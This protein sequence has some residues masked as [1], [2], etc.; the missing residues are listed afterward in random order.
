MATY[1]QYIPVAYPSLP[2]SALGYNTSTPDI[3]SITGQQPASQSLQMTSAAQQAPYQSTSGTGSSAGP[4]GTGSSAGS[5]STGSSNPYANDPYYNPT[6]GTGLANNVGSQGVGG[7][8]SSAPQV[9]QSGATVPNPLGNNST[10]DPSLKNPNAR[11]GIGNTGS[12]SGATPTPAIA[13][14]P[15]GKGTAQT[16]TATDG[17]TTTPSSSPSSSAPYS[18]PTQANYTPAVTAGIGNQTDAGATIDPTTRQYTGGVTLGMQGSPLFANTPAGQNNPQAQQAMANAQAGVGGQYTAANVPAEPTQAGIDYSNPQQ[19]AT[20]NSALGATA[21]GAAADYQ[22]NP[23]FNEAGQLMPAGTF[24][25]QNGKVCVV[26]APY[27]PD[28][29]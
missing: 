18:Y 12:T 5:G 21:S 27:D 4:G 9:P 23:S 13:S 25:G 22:G 10:S 8:S 15:A 2:G 19:Y 20:Y 7:S 3:A 29:A 6:P 24:M 1:S 16:G 26:G 11:L 17:S 28:C 14:N